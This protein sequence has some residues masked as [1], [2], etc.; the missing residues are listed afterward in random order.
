MLFEVSK[1]EN[2]LEQLLVLRDIL[3]EAIDKCE[4]M[5]DL[6]SLAKQYRDT[7]QEIDDIR[8][9][10]VEDDEIEDILSSRIADGKPASVR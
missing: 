5:R 6:S 7:L 2:R 10:H 3:A 1:K 8:G 9:V 4:S